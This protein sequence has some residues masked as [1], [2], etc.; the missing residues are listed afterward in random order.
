MAGFQKPSEVDPLLIVPFFDRLFCCL[1][2]KWLRKLWCGVKHDEVELD[3]DGHAIKYMTSQDEE[4]GLEMEVQ[5]ALVS[6][7][8]PKQTWC[9][10]RMQPNGLRVVFIC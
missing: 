2:N 6:N 3:D 4:D 9:T 5:H 1:P 7:V 8:A 10:C